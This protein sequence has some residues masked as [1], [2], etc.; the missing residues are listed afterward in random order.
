MRLWPISR[1][2][3]IHSVVMRALDPR[4]HHFLQVNPLAAVDG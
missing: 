4:I 3:L 2:D 1:R